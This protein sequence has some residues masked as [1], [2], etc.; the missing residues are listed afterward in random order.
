MT[1]A[2]WLLWVLCAGCSVPQAIVRSSNGLPDYTHDEGS[3]R[4]LDV[5]MRD[6]VKLKTH[7]LMPKG[8]ERAPIVL[9]RNPYPRDIIFTFS[10]SVFVRYGIGCVVQ[11]VRG[12]R[13]SEGEWYP[14]VNEVEDGEDTLAWLDAQPFAESIALYGQSYLAGTALAASTNLPA[15]VKTLVLAVFGTDLRSSISERGLFPH[16]LITAWA[17]Y[18]PSR[19]RPTDSWRSYEVALAHRPHLEC[20]VAA[21]G[22]KRDWYRDWLDAALPSAAVW[23][24]PA[25]VKF[26]AVPPHIQVPVLYI[27]GFD[28]PFLVAGLDTFARLGSRQQSHL[29]ILPTSHIGSQPGELQM[30]EADGQYLWKLPVPWLLHYL[31]G[32]PLPYPATGVTSW[33]RGELKPVHREA[34]PPA[35][36]D[37]A[38]VLQPQES[39]ATPC[40]QRQLGGQAGAPSPVS[41]RYNPLHP[42]PSE[43]GARGLGL[44]QLVAGTLTPGPV[45]QT[46][47]CKRADVLRFVTPAFSTPKRIAGVMRLDLSARSSAKDTAFYAKLVDIDADGTAV[48]LTDG[49]ATLRLPTGRDEAWVPYEPNSVRQVEIDFFPTE[50]VLQPGHRLGLWV[51]SSNYPALSAHLNTEEPWFRATQ[52]LLAQQTLELGGPSVLLLHVAD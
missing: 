23:A 15:K 19:A 6:G 3:W 34:W 45:R 32:A 47:D 9:M 5:V 49:A 36:R 38:L 10:C 35:T 21:F 48:H 11:D 25:N 8:L 52:P 29:A 31:K 42:W 4:D 37:E 17:A 20:D 39:A 13:E 28:D 7:V 1:R 43:G 22:G 26:K 33:A 14:L 30:P 41:Y 46:W 40:P 27:E 18:M 50:W 12:Q 44:K 16:E 2:V 51:S 24:L